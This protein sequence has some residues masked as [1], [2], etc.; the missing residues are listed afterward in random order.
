VQIIVGPRGAA[1]GEVEVK[2]R[3]TGDRDNMGV[4]GLMTMLEAALKEPAI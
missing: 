2:D 1:G 4:D 3:A